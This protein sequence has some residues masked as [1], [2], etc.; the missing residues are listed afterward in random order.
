MKRGSGDA[1]E[2]K[3]QDI[4]EKF[5]NRCYFLA[6]CS[7]GGECLVVIDDGHGDQ[8]VEVDQQGDCAAQHVPSVGSGYCLHLMDRFYH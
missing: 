7:R 5:G 4:S 6:A 2:R 1:R 3:A 8:T